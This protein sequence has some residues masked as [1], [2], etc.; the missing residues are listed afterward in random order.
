MVENHTA[1]QTMS[2]SDK[3]AT[4]IAQLIIRGEIDPSKAMDLEKKLGVK[5]NLSDEQLA[6]ATLTYE[7]RQQNLLCH[8]RYAPK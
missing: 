8:Q 3:I 7:N 1:T 5:F 4:T 2:M 6:W